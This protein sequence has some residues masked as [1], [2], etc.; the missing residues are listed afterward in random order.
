MY[1]NMYAIVIQR[2]WAKLHTTIFTIFP[3]EGVSGPRAGGQ[4]GDQLAQESEHRLQPQQRQGTQ[5][6][7]IL[8]LPEYLAFHTYRKS[9]LHRRKRMFQVRL[10]R[11]STDMG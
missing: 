5:T 2:T 8:P 10:S 11:C 7:S 3:F 1:H 4:P 6:R 9:V